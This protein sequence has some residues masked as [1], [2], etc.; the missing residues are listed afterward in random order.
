MMAHD[1]MPQ[2][3]KTVA[4]EHHSQPRA[5]KRYVAVLFVA[6]AALLSIGLVCGIRYGYRLMESQWLKSD[7]GQV[8]TPGGAAKKVIKKLKE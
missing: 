7:S 2:G 8:Y 1:R 6:L 4:E 3:R 5:R